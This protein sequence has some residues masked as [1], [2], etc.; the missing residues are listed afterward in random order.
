MYGPQAVKQETTS[1]GHLGIICLL[2]LTH[3]V[4]KLYLFFWPRY[5]TCTLLSEEIRESGIE[6]TPTSNRVVVVIRYSN[7]FVYAFYR[8]AEPYC[9]DSAPAPSQPSAPAP[10]K[11]YG[12][13]S[14]TSLLYYYTALPVLLESRYTAWKGTD[15][16]KA[17]STSRQDRNTE[18]TQSLFCLNEK[19]RK[20][21]RTDGKQL[22]SVH[23]LPSGLLLY[24]TSLGDES[25]FAGATKLRT[26]SRIWWTRDSFFFISFIYHLFG[27]PFIQAS[28]VLLELQWSFLSRPPLSRLNM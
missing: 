6:K 26:L 14:S 3:K 7:I 10:T 4:A 20:S 21:P 8:A 22:S 17:E 23:P 18:L 19:G 13:G 1:A 11:W 25:I 12:S 24:A 2:L 28:F 5:V 16:E 15:P 27:A 9:F